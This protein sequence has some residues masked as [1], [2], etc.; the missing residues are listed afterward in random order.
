MKDGEIQDSFYS[1]DSGFYE[2]LKERVLKRL[3]EKNLSRRG[4]SEIMIK[5]IFLLIGFWGS[6]YKM[7]TTTDD[8]KM[9]ALWS[10]TMGCFAAFIGTCIQHDGN[11]GAFSTSKP[12]NKI[13]G[14]TLDMIGAS[15]FTW[16]IQHM[17]GHHP[18][19][20][21]LDL[22]EDKKKE[23]GVDCPIEEK[24]QVSY[25]NYINCP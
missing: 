4:G 8:Y 10:I 2:I 1:W 5:A 17:L 22:E 7:Y 11:H 25:S 3:E 9:A 23:A 6:L 15:A 20:N 21:V 14:W 24:D 13:A 19:T 12:I 18:Y 16:E